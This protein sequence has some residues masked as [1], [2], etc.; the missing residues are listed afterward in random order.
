MLSVQLKF[1]ESTD[2]IQHLNFDQ[3]WIAV[4]TTGFT[5]QYKQTFLFECVVHAVWKGKTS[6]VELKIGTVTYVFVCYW[7]TLWCGTY[8]MY[9][10]PKYEKSMEFSLL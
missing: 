5:K 1:S 6:L 9:N 4:S 7:S 3:I 2:Y 10:T 8:N